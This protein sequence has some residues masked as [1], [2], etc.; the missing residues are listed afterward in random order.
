MKYNFTEK[1]LVK[2]LY[3]ETS[4][5]ESLLLNHDIEKNSALN[6]KM[7]EFKKTKALLDNFSITPPKFVVNKIEDYLNKSKLTA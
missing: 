1:D 3:N 5:M 2:E 7:T 6:Q 4:Y